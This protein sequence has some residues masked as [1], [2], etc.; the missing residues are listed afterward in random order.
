MGKVI[1]PDGVEVCCW[2]RYEHSPHIWWI[3]FGTMESETTIL[4]K[5]YQRDPRLMYC[6]APKCEESFPNH[7]WGS[8][9][10]EGWFRQW[11]GDNWCPKHIP[12]WV[13]GWRANKGK[14]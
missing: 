4:C 13:E 6:S 12:D 8:I 10:L 9:K 14:Y 11:N 5:G 7:A 1:V 2:P 3:G